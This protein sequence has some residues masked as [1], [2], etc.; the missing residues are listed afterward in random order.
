MTATETARFESLYAAHS[1]RVYSYVRRRVD[2]DIVDDVVADVF[3]T[4][5]RRITDAPDGDEALLWL[6]RVAQLVTSGHWRRI[7]RRKNLES[8]VSGVR[9]PSGV[10]II[11]QIVVRD[12]V[13][14]AIQVMN[15]LSSSDREILK[16]S[17]WE[18][19]DSEEISVVLDIKPATARQ[20]LARAK[21]RLVSEFEK[22]VGANSTAFATNPGGAL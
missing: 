8:K 11:D 3:M 10:S 21:K 14:E 7:R 18:Q 13:R 5:W 6:Y 16:L 15:Q 2:T 9:A 4:A 20:R 17:L 19:L 22:K 12:E 1:K